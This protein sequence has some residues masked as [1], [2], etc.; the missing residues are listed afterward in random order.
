MFGCLDSEGVRLILTELTAAYTRPYFDLAS[1]IV[2]GDPPSCGGRICV[3]LDGTGCLVCCGLLDVAEAQEDLLGPEGQREREALYG[4]ERSALDRSGPSVVSING[5]V[6]SLA[7]TEFLVAVTG[8]RV[9]QR[10]LTYYGQTGK[11]TVSRDE[12]APDCYYCTAVRDRREAADVQRYVRAGVG[13]FL[14]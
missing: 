8:L 9:P 2:P 14:R 4:V 3:A 7:V 12:P 5:V 13:S 10:V 1:D 11:V 6:A